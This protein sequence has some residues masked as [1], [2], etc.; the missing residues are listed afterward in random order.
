MNDSAKALMTIPNELD[1]YQER[2]DRET[3]L[4]EMDKRAEEILFEKWRQDI[5]DKIT[6][7][8]GINSALINHPPYHFLNITGV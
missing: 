3:R 6:T 8:N 5:R 2:L 7:N 1:T 4:H